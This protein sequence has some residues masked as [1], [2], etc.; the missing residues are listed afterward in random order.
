[1]FL[2]LTNGKNML[3]FAL[4]NSSWAVLQILARVELKI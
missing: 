4:D 2:A 3:L 1:M